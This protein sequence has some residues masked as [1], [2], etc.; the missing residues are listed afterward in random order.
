LTS[1]AERLNY[2]A[3]KQLGEEYLITN[4]T[5]RHLFLSRESLDRL[6]ADPAQ[7]DDDT[8]DALIRRHFLLA[9][10]ESELAAVKATRRH[11]GHLLG[12]TPLHIFVLTNAC[13][14]VCTYCQASASGLTA[15]RTDMSIDT[16]RRCMDVAFSSP[17]ASITIEFQGGEPL[18]NFKTLRYVVEEATR[19][20]E[21]SAKN[22]A[23]NLVSNL[24][25]LNEDILRFLVDSG[26]HVCTSLDGPADLHNSNR[27]YPG[28][29]AYESTRRALTD[30]NSEL[31]KIGD[32]RR[33]Q[34]LMTTTRASLGRSREIIDQYLDLGLD[35]IFIR[36]LTPLGQSAVEWQRIGYEPEQ[37]VTFYTECLDYLASVNSDRLRIRE[38]HTDIFLRKILGCEQVNYMELRSPCGGVLGQLAYD[39]DGS[40]YTCDEGRMLATTGDASFRLG[41]VHDQ[42]FAALIAGPTAITVCSA[43]CLEA[44]PGCSDCVY[45]PYCGTCPVINLAKSGDVFP[46]PGNYRCGLHGGM[47]DAV[48]SRLRSG[49]FPRS[50]LDFDERHEV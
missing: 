31:A 2:F 46:R 28:H 43:S 33:V 23:F 22:V 39:C 21:A 1:H 26:V 15:R 50:M 48:F 38:F 35:S 20:A 27:P 25:V 14:H 8:R 12:A 10:P 36:P 42:E 16:A 37:F 7:L 45:V 6:V 30:V 9:G 17:A 41:T 13:N 32:P 4:D 24:S 11:G 19:R 44:I 29:N 5:G 47:L 40:V 18:L 49:D 3:F 34:A